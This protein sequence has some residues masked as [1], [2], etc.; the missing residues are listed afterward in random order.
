MCGALDA[1]SI[2]EP[3]SGDPRREIVRVLTRI[4]NELATLDMHV[5]DHPMRVLRS[6]A[7]SVGATRIADVNSSRSEVCV[8][9]IVAAS[10]RIETTN[11]VTMQFVTLE[12]ETGLIELV[13]FPAQYASLGDPVRFPGPFLVRGCVADQN[14]RSLAVASLLPFHRRGSEACTASGARS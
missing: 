5:T 10:R 11:H 2:V 14:E 13:L 12:D 3:R 7:T 6:E 9:G 8:A 1:Y 4:Q